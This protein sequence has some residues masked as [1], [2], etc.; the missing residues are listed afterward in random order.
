MA[1]HE[2]TWSNGKS[3]IYNSSGSTTDPQ[4][5][6]GK[7]SLIHEFIAIVAGT[8]TNYYYTMLANGDTI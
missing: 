5:S 2:P 1:V 4:W 6:Y 7:S 3:V 8:I